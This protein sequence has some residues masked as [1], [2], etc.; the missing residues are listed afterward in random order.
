MARFVGERQ[1]VHAEGMAVNAIR[2]IS[3]DEHALYLKHAEVIRK[4]GK[5]YELLRLVIKAFENFTSFMKQSVETIR[6][7]PQLNQAALV[8]YS[9]E[10]ASLMI[11]YLNVARIF[12]DHFEIKLSRECG[13]SSDQLAE[14]KA[15]LRSE[16][17]ECFSYRF[18]YRLRNY[19]TH[20]GLPLLHFEL[21]RIPGEHASLFI[22]MK[23]KELLASF[24]KWGPDVSKDLNEMADDIYI[25]RVLAENINSNYFIYHSLYAE[26]Y[27]LEILESTQW[28]REFIGDD[29]LKSGYAIAQDVESDN[30]E[31]L[32]TLLDFIV[33][34]E[35]KRAVEVEKVFLTHNTPIEIEC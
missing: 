33:V 12:V 30:G 18:L 23:P 2:L 13:E 6:S 24:K 29:T 21:K 20:C 10:S 1:L 17:N 27:R 22:T 16:F 14:Y 7:N 35:V 19:T 32:D 8:D 26:H 9:F 11:N 34:D 25:R 15:L 31:G 4:F 28:L 5:D 3:D